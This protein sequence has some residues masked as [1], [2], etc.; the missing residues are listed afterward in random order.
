M[1][2][3]EGPEEGKVVRLAELTAKNPATGAVQR[4]SADELDRI[5]KT[6]TEI[7]DSAFDTSLGAADTTSAGTYD[8]T[9][10]TQ[11]LAT[12]KFESLTDRNTASLDGEIQIVFLP[13]LDEQ[14]AVR[15]KNFVSKT[16]FALKFREGWE[17]S[18]VK[19]K[20]DSTPV[21]IELLNTVKSA[22]DA[23]TDIAQAEIEASKKK[24]PGVGDVL[25]KQLR[26]II[27]D[28]QANLYF[29]VQTT[30]IKPGVYRINK[31]WEIEG[32]L[33]VNGCGLLAKLGLETFTNTEMVPAARIEKA[34]K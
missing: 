3:L 24:T 30:Y 18:D 33:G 27:G 20:H 26:A 2:F 17:L 22:V 12:P 7:A 29:L 25:D 10:D 1:T 28:K 9:P 19:A 4:V 13:D 21:A 23:A 11:S 5:R 32:G 6:V 16:A 15:S 31:P 8:V 14:Y 34:P